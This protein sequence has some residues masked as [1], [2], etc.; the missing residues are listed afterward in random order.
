[1]TCTTLSIDLNIVEISFRLSLT[2]KQRERTTNEPSGLY[3][4]NQSDY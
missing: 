1:M 4:L 3:D 2:K